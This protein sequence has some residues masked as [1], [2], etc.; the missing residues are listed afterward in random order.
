[1]PLFRTDMHM[2]VEQTWKRTNK[3][4]KK[5]DWLYWIKPE[6]IDGISKFDQRFSAEKPCDSSWDENCPCRSLWNDDWCQRFYLFGHRGGCKM[7]Q[8]FEWL[9]IYIGIYL[10][11]I[12]V[13]FRRHRARTVLHGRACTRAWNSYRMLLQ[14]AFAFAKQITK[15]KVS[16]NSW[17]GSTTTQLRIIIIEKRVRSDMRAV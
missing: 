4:K 11:R 14:K 5:L 16:V 3:K 1:M 12:D 2:L 8:T 9:I 17:F 7:Y 6:L 15:M 10:C 13:W